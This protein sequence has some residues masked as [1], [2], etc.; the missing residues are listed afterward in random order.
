VGARIAIV[1]P[2]DVERAGLEAVLQA[3]GHKVVLSTA[4]PAVA[5][6]KIPKLAP[7]LVLVGVAPSGFDGSDIE[8]AIRESCPTTRILFL[9]NTSSEAVSESASAGPLNGMILKA[10]SLQELAATVDRVLE[11]ETYIDPVIARSLVAQL[12][13]H[14]APDCPLATLSPRERDVFCLLQRGMSNSEIAKRLGISTRT[15]KN[16]VS[17]VLRKLGLQRRSQVPALG[18][19]LGAERSPVSSMETS[20]A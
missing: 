11:G 10:A 20:N 13:N 4:S 17:A 7:D 19:E 12:G 18:A 8:K 5:V 15:A 9:L 3:R 16:H 14:S 2:F 1:D 6:K